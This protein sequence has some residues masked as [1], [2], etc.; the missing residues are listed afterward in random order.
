MPLSVINCDSRYCNNSVYIL[1]NE[2]ESNIFSMKK[3]S[4]FSNYKENI[5]VTLSLD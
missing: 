3:I 4:D 1:L 2:P 5:I